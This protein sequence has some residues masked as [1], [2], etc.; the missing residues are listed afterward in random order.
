MSDDAPIIVIG[1]GLA[2]AACLNELTQTQSAPVL[3]VERHARGATQASTQNA[4]LIRSHASNPYTAALA[5]QGARWWAQQNLTPF[6]HCGSILVGGKSSELTA[7]FRRADHRWI[8]QDELTERMGFGPDEPVRAFFNPL[9]G[10]ADAGHLTQALL[11][12][13]TAHGATLSFNCEATLEGERLFLDGTEVSYRALV[14][15]GGAWSSELLALPTQAFSR[16]L[17]RCAGTPLPD[18]APWLW[19]LDEELYLRRDG[20]GLIASICDEEVVPHPDPHAWPP[21]RP[22]LNEELHPQFAQ[23][24]SK[25]GPLEIHECWA[26]LRTLTPDD[27]F[28]LGRDP[29]QTSIYWCAGLGGHGVT[30]AVPAARLALH[31]LTQG[32]LNADELTCAQA[33]HP[34]RFATLRETWHS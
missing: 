3:G 19:D 15:A 27:G 1:A 23:R 25:L 9:D 8:D 30:C 7:G 11:D 5:R 31:E 16:H 24:W 21:T 13:A 6:E 12:Q 34:R 28:I 33:H 29:R 32:A 20:D 17:F 22:E 26:G 10:M 14:I 4:G 18:G 2:G